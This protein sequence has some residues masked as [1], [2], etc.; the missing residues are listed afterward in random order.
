MPEETVIINGYTVRIRYSAE[1]HPDIVSN[2]RDTLEKAKKIPKTTTKFD[3]KG[4]K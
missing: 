2:M 1:K 3:T 4:Q